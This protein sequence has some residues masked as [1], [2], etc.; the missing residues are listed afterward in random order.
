MYD[1][2]DANE[3]ASQ[4]TRTGSRAE[5]FRTHAWQGTVAYHF[6]SYLPG[7]DSLN[8]VR[9]PNSVS[10][11]CSYSA[12]EL[13]FLRACVL[14]LRVWLSA[15]LLLLRAWLSGRVLLLRVWLS[16]RVLLP[17]T[18]LSALGSVLSLS[19][20]ARFVASRPGL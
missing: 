1:L 2:L 5:M 20:K 14:F 15:R 6:P 13:L 7:A 4:T 3:C 12:A 9:A 11:N 19:M 8:D 17:R 18:W 16:G 10:L